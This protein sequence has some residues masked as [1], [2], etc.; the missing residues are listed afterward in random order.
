M[1]VWGLAG[2]NLLSRNLGR[3]EHQESGLRRACRGA[4]FQR[5]FSPPESAL[6]RYCS[7]TRGRNRS[8]SRCRSTSLR[9]EASPCSSR[10]EEL[11]RKVGRKTWLNSRASSRRSAQRR[12]K[13]RYEFERIFEK[14]LENLTRLSFTRVFRLRVLGEFRF[15]EIFK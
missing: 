7:S 12:R 2:R 4:W 5:R 9:E 15:V 10:W 3:R 14:D 11:P 6:P 8:R 13:I 1:K